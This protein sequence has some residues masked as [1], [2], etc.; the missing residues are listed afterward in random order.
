MK[1]VHLPPWGKKKKIKKY[2]EKDEEN[3]NRKA[4]DGETV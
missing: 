3:G 1:N 2:E 4:K